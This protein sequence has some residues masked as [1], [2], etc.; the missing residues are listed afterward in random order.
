MHDAGG[1]GGGQRVGDLD[2]Q[3]QSKVDQKISFNPN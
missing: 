2:R 1:V 3:A